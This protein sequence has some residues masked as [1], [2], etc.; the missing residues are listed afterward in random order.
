MSFHRKPGQIDSCHPIPSMGSDTFW[1]GSFVVCGVAI[2]QGD[3]L[4][5]CVWGA[6]ALI[7]TPMRTLWRYR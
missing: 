2:S 4:N 3:L 6:G 1:L 7:M 5:T